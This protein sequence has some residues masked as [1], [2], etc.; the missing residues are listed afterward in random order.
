MTVCESKNYPSENFTHNFLS[1]CVATASAYD[2]NDDSRV[3]GL[4]SLAAPGGGRAVAM[5]MFVFMLFFV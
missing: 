4:I 3:A 1:T 2:D 5:F